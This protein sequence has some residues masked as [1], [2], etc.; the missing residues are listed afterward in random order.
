MLKRKLLLTL[1]FA[2]AAFSFAGTAMAATSVSWISPTDGSSFNVGTTVDLVGQASA[3]GGTGGSGLDLVLVLDSSGSMSGTR[4]AAQKTAA[5][6]LVD[7]LPENTTSVSIVEYDSDANTVQTLLSLTSATNKAAIVAAINSVD[8]SGGTD[9]DDGI[10]AATTELTSTRADSSRQQ[11]MV[12]MSDG[13]SDAT[14]A[15][16]AANSAI[17]SGVEAV[18]SVGISSSH[19]VSTMQK[20]VSGAD[21]FYGTADDIGVYTDGTNI[22]ALTGLFSGT[23]GNL[24]GIDH[25]TILLDDG[26]LLNSDDGDFSV[27]GVG[28][29][30]LPDWVIALGAQTFVATAYA[31]DGTTSIATLTLNGTAGGGGASQTPEPATMLLF[32]LGLLGFTGVTRRKK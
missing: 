1:V 3:S 24:V 13:G 5:L 11:M 12:V 2:F 15:W 9:I 25:V 31:T 7:A 27:D 14:D 32:G 17:N 29:F 4:E 21:G 6:A 18:H 16:N 26:T 19:T 8:A 28:N 10:V 23:A 20:I 30:T 22:D